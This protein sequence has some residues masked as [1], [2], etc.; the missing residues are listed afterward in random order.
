MKMK[1]KSYAKINL[2][3]DILGRRKDGYHELSTIFQQI[4]FYDDIILE[5]DGIDSYVDRRE[6]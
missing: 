2:T 4:N 1:L 5:N 6:R 3:L